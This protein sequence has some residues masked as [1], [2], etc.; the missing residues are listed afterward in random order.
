MFVDVRGSLLPISI[1]Q[2]AVKRRVAAMAIRPA[3]ESGRAAVVG[4]P[5]FNLVPASGKGASVWRIPA[6]APRAAP[7]AWAASLS[8]ACRF[9]CNHRRPNNEGARKS[10]ADT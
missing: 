7:P 4:R 9:D 5:K 8:R 3:P 1:W 10:E 2:A 6:M